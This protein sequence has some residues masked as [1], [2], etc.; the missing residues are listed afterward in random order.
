MGAFA[1]LFI[2]TPEVC[3]WL[4]C[5]AYRCR[6]TVTAGLMLLQSAAVLSMSFVVTIMELSQFRV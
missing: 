5:C 1:V 4:L 3:C 2:Y 6:S